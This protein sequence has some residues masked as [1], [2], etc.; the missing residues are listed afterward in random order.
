M[1][2]GAMGDALPVTDPEHNTEAYDHIAENAFRRVTQYPLSTFSIDVDTASYSNVR[3]FLTNRQLPPAGAVRVEELINYFT[4]DYPQPQKD[5]PFSVNIEAAECPWQPANRL[6][7]IGL[8]GK[9]LVHEQR[10]VSNLVFL[11]DVSGS[12]QSANKLPLVRE[13]LKML[14]GQLGENDRVSIAVY[15]GASGLVLPS[16]TCDRQTEILSAIDNLQAGGST[17]GGAGIQLAYQVAL[18]NFIPRGTNRVILCTDG[19][20]NVGVTNQ[21]D[22]IT[23]IEQKAQSKVFLTVLGFGMGNYKDSTL[24]K[25]ADKGNGQ[26]AYIDSMREARKVFIEQMQGTLITIAKDVKIQVEFNPA[27]VAAYRL[28]GYENRLLAN[29]DF[30]DDRKDAGEIG[31]GHTVT[32]LYEVVPANGSH[33]PVVDGEGPG[34]DPLRYQKPAVA[35]EAAASDELLTVK[36]R[37]KQPEGDESRLIEMPAIDRGMKLGEASRDF[38]WAAAV[39]EFGQIL[40]NSQFKGIGTLASVQELAGSAIGPDPHGHRAEFL[41][42]VQSAQSLIQQTASR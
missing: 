23:L 4:Y 11:V 5:V 30:N 16:T 34:V 29:E 21:S 7:R 35:S 27:R 25:L 32:A 33:E 38:V 13:G 41:K 8:K 17:N 36:L 12:M 40:R 1:G 31:A 20:F 18:E 6:V 39:A 2:L 14:V 3:R 37:Y 28:V 22:L 19:D 24:E 42:L 9:E 26:Y 10:P 15:A